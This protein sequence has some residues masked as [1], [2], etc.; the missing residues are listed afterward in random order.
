E[1]KKSTLVI[2]KSTLVIKKSTSEVKKSTLVIK[3]STFVIK[4]ST[5]SITFMC[6][7]IKNLN[8]QACSVFNVFLMVWWLRLTVFWSKHGHI[9]MKICV[10]VDFSML[11]LNLISKIYVAMEDFALEIFEIGHKASL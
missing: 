11:K 7:Y 8:M 2:K 10:F 4:K 9:C 1:V 3:K 5:L 6:M